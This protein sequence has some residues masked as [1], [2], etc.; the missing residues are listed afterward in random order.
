MVNE[1]HLQFSGRLLFMNL[2]EMKKGSLH[3]NLSHHHDNARKELHT[4]NMENHFISRSVEGKEE[5][6]LKDKSSV[7]LLSLRNGTQKN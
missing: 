6:L 3:G 5:N 4:H 1:N 7:F 2:I